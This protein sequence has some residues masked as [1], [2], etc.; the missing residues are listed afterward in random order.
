MK[1][2]ISQ[3]ADELEQDRATLERELTEIEMLLGQVKVEA[4]RHEARRVE[5]E[6]RLAALE[7]DGRTPPERLGEARAQLMSQTRRA[8]TMQGQLEVLLGKQR[9]LQRYQ[10]RVTSSLPVLR[11]ALGSAGVGEQV[12]PAEPAAGAEPVSSTRGQPRSVRPSPHEVLAA[13][14]EL[15]REIARQMHDGPAQ[16]IA[17]IALQAQIVQRLFDRNLDGARGELNELVG[18]VEDALKATK[19]FIFDIRPMVLDDLGLVPTL[20]RSATERM[21]RVS[22]SIRFESIGSDGRLPSELES[23]LYRIVDDAVIAY[24]AAN[25]PE[26]LVRL[27]WSDTELRTTVQ[28]RPLVIDSDQKRVK[29]AVAA[30]A[31]DKNVPAALAT[32]IRQQ[33]DDDAARDFGLTAETWSDISERADS[34]GIAVELSEDGWLLEAV[35][36]RS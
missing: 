11:D 15:R 17:N 9:A 19:E 10:A 16:S 12:P 32:M 1:P 23:A 24:T 30:A 13:Q 29:D 34:A 36:H 22:T 8:T 2:N 27:D 31:R 33:E 3:L 25:S 14:E 4:E 26:V 18:M 21:R 20:R 28:G 5:A 35:V 7:V 6:T